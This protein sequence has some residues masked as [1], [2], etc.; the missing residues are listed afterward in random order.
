VL[1]D[2]SRKHFK[3]LRLDATYELGGDTRLLGFAYGTRQDFTRW[4]TRPRGG[5]WMQREESYG[6][7]VQGAGANLAGKAALA[8]GALDWTLGLEQVREST[9]YG[10]WDGLIARQRT[11][12]A[13]DDRRTRLNNTAAYGQ[14]SWKANGWLQ[15]TAGL[16]ADRFS[17]D[18]RPLGPEAGT[19][20]CGRMQTRRHASPK[21]GLLAQIG[22]AVAL[23][24]NW[25]EGFALPSDFAKYALGARDLGTN[26]FRQTELGVQWSPSPQWRVDAAVYRITSSQEIR[27][28]APGEYQNFGATLRKGAEVQ[29]HWMPHR[30]WHV[31]W[32]YGRARSR[33][34]Q[35]ADAALLGRQVTGVPGFTSTLHARWRPRADL[36]VHAMLRHVGRSALNASN[37][38]WA[39]GYRWADLGLQYRLPSHGASLNVWLRNVGNARYASTTV[40]IGGE[41]LVA[42]GAPR[43]VQVGL[44]LSL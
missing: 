9:D 22:P 12:P 27:N 40:L 14:A 31:E 20:P 41:R 5:G 16:R 7:R 11:A 6:R 30:D 42:P 35:H 8:G 10:Y 2:G 37:T 24:A 25:S 1:D 38:E 17:G 34:T 39:G 28:T 23:R 33:V 13:L 18:C 21:L 36:T 3:T 29:L 44:Q 19:D 26:V 43:T 32:V 15:A 4:F